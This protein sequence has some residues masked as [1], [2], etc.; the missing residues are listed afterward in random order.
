M[1]IKIPPENL[2][3]KEN[4]SVLFVGDCAVALFNI[5]GE[6]HALD[7]TC[8][9]RGGSLGEGVVT[10]G[11]VTCPWHGWEFNCR[12]GVAVENQKVAVPKYR[13]VNQDDGYYLEWINE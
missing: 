11:V 1:L 4:G 6:L 3:D 8:P 13:V 2:P 7:N 12:T 9:H 5:N 10:A